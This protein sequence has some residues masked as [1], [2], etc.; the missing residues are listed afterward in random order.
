M[1]NK[2][3]RATEVSVYSI[4]VLTKNR[5]KVYRVS[6]I[7]VL[8]VLELKKGFSADD[9]TQSINPLVKPR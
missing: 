7:R 1:I 5:V 8:N 6:V 3:Q 9:Y 2:S 4:V